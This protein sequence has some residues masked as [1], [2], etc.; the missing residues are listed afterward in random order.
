MDKV[1]SAPPT[2]TGATVLVSIV[3]F[4]MG[5]TPWLLVNGVFSELPILASILPEKYSIAAFMVICIQCGNILA[6]TFAFTQSQK[7]TFIRPARVVLGVYIL[8]LIVA[9]LLAFFWSNEVKITDTITKSIPLL[10]LVFFS[11]VVGSM[12]MVS[13]FPFASSYGVTM[14]GALSAGSG[15][16]GFV[17]SILAL[18]QGAEN[19]QPRFSVPVFFFILAGVIALTIL[20]FIW[21][22]L[23]KLPRSFL[24][25]FESEKTPL[26]TNEI[27]GDS[28]PSLP[29][30]AS[31]KPIAMPLF[32]E[33]Y[34]S[35]LQYILVGILPYAFNGYGET[36][37]VFLFWN[38]FAPIIVGAIG[39]LATIKIKY[40]NLLPQSLV[41]TGLWIFITQPRLSVQVFFFILAGV[42]ALT[43][44]CFIWIVLHKLPR[45]F[46]NSFESE[47]TPL[48]TNEIEGDSV[49]SLP[50]I[51]SLKPIAMPLFH[52][53]YISILQYI[54]VGILPYAFNGYGETSRVFLF[55]NT[56]APIIVGAIG[57]LATIKI[58]YLNLLPQSLVQT[59][60]W[61][62]ITVQCFVQHDKTVL[63]WPIATIVCN[64]VYTALYGYEDTLN[65]QLIHVYLEPQYFERGSRFMGVFNQIGAFTG[66]FIGFFLVQYALS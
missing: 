44:L 28:V 7:R 50:L 52:E 26:L 39:R 46:L 24:N 10:V 37:R 32:H 66:S 21:I 22:V 58:K 13:V 19:P 40:L 54:L 51:A 34:I 2:S 47:K 65:Y 62:F 14:I 1:S 23:H 59:G 3:F 49:P 33:C 35:I 53:C 60:L 20:C 38:T 56:F 31:L 55:W 17:P 15:A 9:F 64:T 6:F 43:I 61:I 16:N 5:L 57:R 36:S 30:I 45:S 48:L 12:S 8:A 27:E 18:I 25:S 63:A 42:I 11:G 41:Q 4:I 29:L